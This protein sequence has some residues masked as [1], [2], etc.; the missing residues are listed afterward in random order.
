MVWRQQTI[1]IDPGHGGEDYGA[2]GDVSNEKSL[3]LFY[4]EML[5]DILIQDERFLPILTRNKDIELNLSTRKDVA[6]NN[7]CRV[8]LSIHCNASTS[9]RPNDTQFYYYSD[10]KDKP[11][12]DLL[13]AYTD[14]LDRKS[15]KWSRVMYGNY[16]VLRKLQTHPIAAVLIEI[17]FITNSDDEKMMNDPEYQDRYVRGLYKGLKAYFNLK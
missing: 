6:I 10:V 1:C 9:H 8:F 14:R 13:F 3:N 16:Y 17:G 11:L 15:S 2:V 12:A 4:A 7:D 5:Y